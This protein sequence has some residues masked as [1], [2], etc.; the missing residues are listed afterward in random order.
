MVKRP[1]ESSRDEVRRRHPLEF[2]RLAKHF[3]LHRTRELDANPPRG[4]KG[5]AEL[6]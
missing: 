6:S 3:N 5:H 1:V 2:V 4:A